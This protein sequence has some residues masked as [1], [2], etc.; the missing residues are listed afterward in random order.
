MALV[1]VHSLIS[2]RE[3]EHDREG[4][5]ERPRHQTPAPQFFTDAYG[6]YAEAILEWAASL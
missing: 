5:W 6:E 1:V 2:N 3:Q 4:I